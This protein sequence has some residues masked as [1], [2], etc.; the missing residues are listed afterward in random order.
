MS[1]RDTILI[2]DDMEINRVIL[3]GLFQDEYH[4]L[5]AE[6]GEQALLLLKQCHGNI[7]TIL[8]DVVMPVMDGYRA[9]EAMRDEGFLAEIPVVVITV[10]NSLE[11]ELRSFD[12]GAS[13]IIVKPF[14][15]HVVKRRVHNVIELY[16]HKHNLEELVNRQAYKLKESNSVLVDVLSSVIESRSQE[17]GQHIKR[18][19]L[20]TRVLLEELE[21]NCPEYGLNRHVIEVIA[22]ASA[23]HDI[24][25]IAI[26]DRILKKPGHL[27]PEEFEI[28]KTH[29][30]KGC[31]IL[32]SL[33][34]MSDR[35]YLQKAYNICRYHHERWDGSGYPDG[36]CGDAIPIC[37]QVVSVV[38]AYDALTSERVYKKAVSHQQAA[39]MILNG[40]CGMFSPRLLE[41]FKTVQPV[42]ALLCSRYADGRMPAGEGLSGDESGLAL[43]DSQVSALQMEQMKYFAM[44][45]YENTMVAEVD[46]LSGGYHLVYAPDQQSKG[47]FQ[48]TSLEDAIRRYIGEIVMPE[49]RDRMRGVWIEELP[50]FFEEGRFKQ[51]WCHRVREHSGWSW[52]ELTILR[53]DV[54]HP[55]R[56][57]ALLLW[58]A[59]KQDEA[60]LSLGTGEPVKEV[61]I[62]AVRDSDSCGQEI[63]HRVLRCTFRCRNDRWLTI[64]EM[65]DGFMG[66]GRDEIKKRFQDRY[67]EMIHPDDRERIKRELSVQLETGNDYELEYRVT[68]KAGESNWVLNKGCML[69][70]R[71]GLET[72]YS[73][74]IDINQT[75]RAQEE[76]RLGLERYKIIMEQT[77]DIFFEWDIETDTV[78]YSPNWKEKFG[79]IPIS[80][81]ISQ[82]IPKISH[83]HP[84]DMASFGGFMEKIRTGSRY[85]ELEFRVSDARGRYQWCKLRATTQFDDRGRACKAIGIVIDINNEKKAAQELKARAERDT[86]TKLYNKDSARQRIEH[87]LENRESGEWAALFIIDIDNFKMVND[88]YGHMFGDAVLTKIASQLSRL[89]GSGDVL[90]RIGGDEFM[91]L[92]RG[93]LADVKADITAER[94]LKCF[95]R[96]QAE[97]PGDCRLSSSIGIG[98][99]P[100]DGLDFQ[101]LFQRADVALYHAKFCGKKQYQIYDQFMECMA[102]GQ[103][104]VRQAAASTVIES[105]E[106]AAALMLGDLL[107]RAFNILSKAEK[108][109]RAVDQVLELLGERLQ[110][111]RTYV[112]ENSEDNLFYSNTFEWCAEGVRSM[113]AHL[114][115]VSYSDIGS[116]IKTRFNERGV[117]Y[118]DDIET[119]P[120]KLRSR[121]GEQEVQ[122]ILLCAIKDN[123]VF[124][125]WVGFDDCTSKCL[126]TIN[127]IEVLS[128]ISELLSL[129]LLKR[130]AQNDLM[131]LAGDLRSV[132]DHQNSWIFVMDL[133]TY[134]LLYVNDKTRRL[135]PDARMGMRCYEAFY[136]KD[137]PCGNCPMDNLRKHGGRTQEVYN[138]YLKVW[139]LADA[140]LIRWGRKE[141]G[142]MACHDITRYKEGD[143]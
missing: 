77:N 36:L 118:C 7:A 61:E 18:V 125:G 143:T 9:M 83:L 41:C 30:V 138:S 46:F 74:I 106:G 122:S 117:L 63:F 99:C 28:M 51:S 141:A 22:S 80:S 116:D 137:A 97:L 75:K 142:L 39:N 114:Q 54:E 103:N 81:K 31:Q 123:G 3:R 19:R 56:K 140:S 68:D 23:L 44:L 113:K 129:F 17:T 85:G 50:L 105:E 121:L 98:M 71:N 86:L 136:R 35:E 1:R 2:V 4:L 25:K 95:D 76:L 89:F 27:T 55:R 59:L 47:M 62:M 126:W 79:Y 24:G 90:A 26:E 42:L 34:R 102:Y 92:C 109:D 12:L 84:D 20:L 82:K 131:E 139:C 127:Q 38:D 133:E 48:G 128:F 87:I 111:S 21:R 43:A 112:F 60:P 52:Y 107:P 6:N 96:V 101:T 45:R 15:P 132:L 88:Q 65:D 134:E 119:L 66:Y 49:D 73:V 58:K 130:R 104:T 69:T 94:I 135:A 33:E 70:D 93:D 110:V 57:N 53:I 100:G 120:P 32:E 8:L 10:D 16:L 40:K 64:L 37:A 91:A 29:T 11:G 5:E 13:D 78:V 124:R 14:E 67:V 115:N 72:L 108:M